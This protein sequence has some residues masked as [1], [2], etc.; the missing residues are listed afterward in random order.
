MNRK[1][2]KM[3]DE[4]DVMVIN[5]R[6]KPVKV[7]EGS[8]ELSVYMNRLALT[9]KYYVRKIGWNSKAIKLPGGWGIWVDIDRAG[10][11]ASHY[12]VEG[13]ISEDELE[14]LVLV[15]EE[16]IERETEEMLREILK[17]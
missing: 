17:E 9:E 11:S 1:I 6:G 3:L 14:E 4:H 13:K 12:W 8:D 16:K 10:F 5:I 15:L 7:Y 2:R